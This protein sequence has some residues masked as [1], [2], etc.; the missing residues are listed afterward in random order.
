M[1]IADGTRVS[2]GAVGP[3]DDHALVVARDAAAAGAD[4]DHLHGR[5]VDR[6]AAALLV[7]DEVDLER[8]HD[9]RLAAVDGTEL[10]RGAAHVEGDDVLAP[11]GLADDRAHEDAG[12]WPGFDDAHGKI[13]G[14]VGRDEPAARLHHEQVSGDATLRERLFEVTQVTVDD[15]LH[16]GI[17]NGGVGALILAELRRD[18]R[19]DRHRDVRCA[20]GDPVADAP[21]VLGP[22]I[23]VQQRDGHS[24][25]TRGEHGVDGPVDRRLVERRHD[26]TVGPH[27]LDTSAICRRCTSG[28]DLSM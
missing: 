27:A 1:A 24:L 10:G 13:A 9:R 12:G 21:L 14:E 7:A 4:L 6:Q 5:H 28:R 23:G 18:L 19:G 8:R 15:R 25:A 22:R 2:A 17:R 11:L 3:D 20:L 26:R 16:V